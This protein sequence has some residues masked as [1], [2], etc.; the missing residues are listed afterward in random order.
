MWVRG[1][2]GSFSVKILSV[3]LLT[4]VRLLL[5]KTMVSI[6]ALN[7]S[8]AEERSTVFSPGY[9]YFLSSDARIVALVQK[10]EAERMQLELYTVL[11]RVV[12]SSW[13][14]SAWICE[15]CKKVIANFS[16]DT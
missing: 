13:R 8:A 3:A 16:V 9:S 11:N 7:E 12:S 5:N 6:C 1:E 4:G 15:A 10:C 14:K 2:G